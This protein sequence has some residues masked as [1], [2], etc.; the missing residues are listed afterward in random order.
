MSDVDILIE[1]SQLIAGGRVQREIAE[2][3]V[4]I[5]ERV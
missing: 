4:L 1:A 3:R 2:T 5:Y